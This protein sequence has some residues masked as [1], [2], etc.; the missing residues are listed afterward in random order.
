MLCSAD[1]P[2]GCTGGVLAA[3]AKRR[4]LISFAYAVTDKTVSGD[5]WVNGVKVGTTRGAFI[6]G[7]FDITA[8]VVPGNPAVGGG[9]GGPPPPRDSRPGGATNSL[10]P[11]VKNT[12]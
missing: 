9:G 8:Q 3:R 6:R 7:I 11:L 1:L 2:V 10:M 4:S 12:G 5:V